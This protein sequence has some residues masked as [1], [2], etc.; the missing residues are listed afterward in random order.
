[1]D[2]VTSCLDFTYQGLDCSHYSWTRGQRETD[3]SKRGFL[4][5]PAACLPTAHLL[6][7]TSAV[8]HRLLPGLHHLPPGS[9]CLCPPGISWVWPLLLVLDF[10][11][12][13]CSDLTI[14][15]THGT[16]GESHRSPEGPRVAKVLGLHFRMH[17]ISL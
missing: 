13:F 2:E 9:T 7:S 6:N 1:M 12:L 14:P 10:L 4:L 15:T 11:W 8:V 3:R 17:L 5:Q 16:Q